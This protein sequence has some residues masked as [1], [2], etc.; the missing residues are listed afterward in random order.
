MQGAADEFRILDWLEPLA[1][2]Y[3]QALVA[4]LPVWRTTPRAVLHREAG[5]PPVE[6]LVQEKRGAYA[7]RLARIPW[8]HPAPDRIKRWVLERAK[9]EYGVEI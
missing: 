4:A 3:R 9:D 2:V 7:R 8:C 6:L 1:T 5:E